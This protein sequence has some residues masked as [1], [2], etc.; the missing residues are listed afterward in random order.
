MYVQKRRNHRT[1]NMDQA[2]RFKF[3]E[4][5]K[6]LIQ[7]DVLTPTRLLRRS[8][9]I[10][11]RM[12]IANGEYHKL[13]ECLN[14]DEI[15]PEKME[16]A[17]KQSIRYVTNKAAFVWHCIQ[18]V[19]CGYMLRDEDRKKYHKYSDNLRREIRMLEAER[20]FPHELKTLKKWNSVPNFLEGAKTE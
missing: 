3:N 17:H 4:E 10:Q 11:E 14:E 13:M 8:L 12:E 19:E 1:S 7:T 15:T 5:I 16:Q 2:K 20:K 18:V 9:E 6:L